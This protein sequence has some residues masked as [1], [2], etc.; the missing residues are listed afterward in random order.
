MNNGQLDAVAFKP[1]TQIAIGEM[2]NKWIAEV[3]VSIEGGNMQHA[4]SAENFESLIQTLPAIMR[5]VKEKFLDVTL[6]NPD[7]RN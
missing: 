6:A 2:G 4:F 7:E 3:M 5:H 1:R